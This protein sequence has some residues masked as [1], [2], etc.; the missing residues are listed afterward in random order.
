MRSHCTIP[1]CQAPNRAHGLCQKHHWR[2]RKYGNPLI[3]SRPLWGFSLTDRFWAKVTKT[4]T[5]WLW[6]GAKS[7]G[8]YGAFNSGNNKII[9]AHRFAYEL[10]V[11]PISQGL[12]LDHLCRTPACVN[13]AHLEPV[14]MQI[15][16]LRGISPSAKAAAKT[17]CPQ[18]HPYDL[19]NTYNQRDGGRVCRACHKA[20]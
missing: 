13:P 19:L 6:T 7:R 15:N 2:W 1:H 12:T 10:L 5:C 11:G 14:T 3:T 16:T 18:G 8:G 9:P 20:S 17:H 4:P